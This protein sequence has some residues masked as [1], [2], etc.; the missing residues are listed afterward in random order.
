M[1]TAE[2]TPT[3]RALSATVEG[4]KAM[5]I[6]LRLEEI[7]TNKPD[8]Q[9][10]SAGIGIA[11]AKFAKAVSGSGTGWVTITAAKILIGALA[12][13]TLP[14][15]GAVYTTPKLRDVAHISV[16]TEE[17]DIFQVNALIQKTL[18]TAGLT[19]DDIHLEPNTMEAA[20]LTTVLSSVTAG[21]YFTHISRNFFHT[22]M[23]A[24]LSSSSPMH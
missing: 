3:R 13:V 7:P 22:Y 19:A 14:I 1:A 9:G 15:D 23:F 20:E 10:A 24:R 2:L 16:F 6:I 4:G 12:G 17:G 18:D 8:A 21:I 11:A 5:R